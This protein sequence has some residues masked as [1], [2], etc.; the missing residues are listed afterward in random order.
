MTSIAAGSP[1]LVLPPAARRAIEAALF[2]TPVLRSAELDERLGAELH[3]KAESLQRTGSFKVRGLL[4]RV[5]C[6]TEAERRR[7]LLI[8]SSG[9]AALGAAFAARAA[10]ARLVAVM[11]EAAVARKVELVRS[12]GAEV[13]Q[14]GIR[15]AAQAFA[16]AERIA[17]ERGLTPLH[18]FDDPLVIAG[19]ATAT[20]ELLQQTGPVD[21]VIAPTSGGGLLCGAVLATERAA[22]STR[23]YG[24]QPE[25]APGIVRSR[26][27]GRIVAVEPAP[28]VA[29]ALIAPGPGAH[30]FPI[31]RRAAEV[32]TVGE[33]TI[34]RAMRLVVEHLKIVVEPSGSVGLAG[35]LARPEL[36]EG[37]RVGVLLSG[38]NV[39][40]EVL[41]AV[42][43][44]AP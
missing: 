6:L 39:A 10:G 17:R 29:D 34:R 1:D 11:P 19:Q 12:L 31:L 20:E 41:R 3:F 16:A 9:N 43:G 42:L 27:A 18:A 15:T 28:T 24:V 26:A 32:F 25:A 35:L 21:L 4:A 14:A 33:S 36:A 23:C 22:P 37:R 7:G 44:S 8:V 30:T 38:G 2:R 40:P 13:I 5:T